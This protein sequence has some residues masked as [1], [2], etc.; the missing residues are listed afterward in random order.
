MNHNVHY[1]AFIVYIERANRVPYHPTGYRARRCIAAVI[2]RFTGQRQ[3]HERDL[4]E[5]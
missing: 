4:H 1:L 2:E 5:G 3:Y